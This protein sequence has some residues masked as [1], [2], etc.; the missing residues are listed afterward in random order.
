M[1]SGLSQKKNYKNMEEFVTN[2][3][4]YIEDNHEKTVFGKIILK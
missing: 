2:F 3:E 1:V 4:K